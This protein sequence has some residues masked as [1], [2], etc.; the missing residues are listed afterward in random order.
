MHQLQGKRIIVTGAAGGIGNAAVQLFTACGAR[1]AVTFHEQAPE[2]PQGVVSA[3]CDI[4]DRAE[5]GRVF[6]ELSAA[7]GGLDALVHAAGRHASCPAHTAAE[8]EWDALLDANVRATAWTNQAAFRHLREHG[9]SIVN[10]GSVEGVRGFAGNA[11]YAASRGAV[12]A[13]TRSVALEWGRCGVRVNCVAPA[14]H[15]AIFD[16]QLAALDP[17][18]RAAMDAQLAALIPLGG[19]MG[20]ALRDLAPVLAFLVSDASRFMTGQTLAVDGGLMMLG[21]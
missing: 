5:V 8:Q 9:G 19:R 15:T 4:T 18:A 1:V 2:L 3:R 16:R 14:I 17:A 20:D 12:M 10:M 11:V 21:S 7:L 13:W 6:D